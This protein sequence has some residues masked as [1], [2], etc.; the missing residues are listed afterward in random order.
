VRKIVQLQLDI[1][2]KRL[3]ERNI[4]LMVS[5]EA[6]DYL[7]KVGFDPQFGAR[8][9]KRV[10]QKQVLNLLSKQLLAG[11]IDTSSPVVL[12]VFDGEMVFRKPLAEEIESVQ[13]SD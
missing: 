10:I 6:L 9:V 8:P 4:E 11:K 13:V 12:D 5:P 3:K 1:L 7:S 2:S